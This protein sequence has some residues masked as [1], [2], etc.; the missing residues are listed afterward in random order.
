MGL[1]IAQLA[2]R[3]SPWAKR[4]RR[5]FMP[6][7]DGVASSVAIDARRGEIIYK[8]DQFD[9]FDQEKFSMNEAVV[10]S[11]NRVEASLNYLAAMNEKPVSYAYEPPA[12]VPWSTG[13]SE[14]HRVPIYDLR[15]IADQFTL[16]TAGF[17]LLTHQTASR[18]SGTRTK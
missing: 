6:R 15:P 18:T 13:E 10:R 16:D 2:V 14:P 17:Q 12:G 5:L 3:S 11:V 9:M 8:N 1:V 4:A 7:R